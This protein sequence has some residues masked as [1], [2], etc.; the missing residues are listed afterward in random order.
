[1]QAVAWPLQ[2]NKSLLGISFKAWFTS[3]NVDPWK[4]VIFFMKVDF[5]APKAF[6]FNFFLYIM[7]YATKLASFLQ[8]GLPHHSSCSP[9]KPKWK[10]INYT[11][12][13]TG[14]VTEV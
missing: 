1:M 4:K 8:L 12:I 3:L 13:L 11:L 7:E 2:A 5:R 10:V 9:F 6:P 14:E